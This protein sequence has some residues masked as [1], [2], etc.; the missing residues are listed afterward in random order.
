MSNVRKTVAGAMIVT[1]TM[2]GGVNLAFAEKTEAQ[3]TAQVQTTQTE[4]QLIMLIKKLIAELLEQVAELHQDGDYTLT[5][6]TNLAELEKGHY[7]GWL[8]VGDQKISTGKFNADDE[9][10]FQLAVDPD[11]VDK[12]V[13]TIEPEGDVDAVPSGIVVLA[14]ELDGED[15]ELSFPVDFSDASASV[16]LATPSNGADTDETSGIWFLTLPGPSVGL[17]LPEL[18]SGWVYEGWAVN[19]GVP[20]TSGRFTQ[21]TGADDF[22]G[23]TGSEGVPPFPGE[24][25]LVNAPEGIDFPIDLA[26]GESKIVISVEPDLGGEDPT[27]IGPAQAK[28]FVLAVPE[29]ADDHENMELDLNEESLPS[30]SATF[31]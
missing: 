26:D 28:P 1:A 6:D 30:G 29:D 8:I 2:F 17:D 18:P 21:N 23:Y 14:G 25:F 9:M 3:Q 24:D 10:E 15:A 7:E 12:V 20:L 31:R 16:I 13:I 27:G 4:A 22:D 5:L 19:Q 11:E